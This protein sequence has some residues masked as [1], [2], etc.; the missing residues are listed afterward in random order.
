VKGEQVAH[1]DQAARAK[2]ASWNAHGGF[3]L[4]EVMIAVAFIGIAMLALL[5]L[6]QSNLASVIRAQDLTRAS[7]LAQQLMS[8]AEAERFP[9]PGQTRGDFSHDYPGQYRNF[10][11]ERTVEVLPQF[12]DVRRVRVSI[13]YGHRFGRRFN[14]LEFMHNPSPPQFPGQNGGANSGAA[15]DSAQ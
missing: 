6:H 4:L 15:D 9:V 7:M 11:W 5:S 8:T 12:P 10:R 14:L 13:I 1:A 2:V 3:T